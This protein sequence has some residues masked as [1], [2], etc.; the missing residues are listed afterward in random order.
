MS[1][2]IPIAEAQFGLFSTRQAASAGVSRHALH[3][4]C[5]TGELRRVMRGI[6]ALAGRGHSRWEAHLAVGLAVGGSGALSHESAAA[7]HGSD[8]VAT[9]LVEV[10]LMR[11][12]SNRFPG[13]TL[14]HR[15]G[16]A[17][18]DLVSKRGSTCN[19]ASPDVPR[20]VRSPRTGSRRTGAR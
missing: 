14:V 19:D 16:L 18:E 2:L 12:L 9:T 4:A 6:Y 1:R 11:A 7:I 20:P 3:R 13:G 8:F 17:P 15:S 10:T 5:E